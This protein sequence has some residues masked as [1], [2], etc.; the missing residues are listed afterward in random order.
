MRW[1]VNI[2]LFGWLWRRHKPIEEKP[3]HPDRGSDLQSQFLRAFQDGKM[4][5]ADEIHFRQFGHWL[6]K[7]PGEPRD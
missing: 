2:F 1:F 4:R 5:E 6:G 7:K 3:R